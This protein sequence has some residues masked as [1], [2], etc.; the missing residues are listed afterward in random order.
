MPTV[1]IE[2]R[3]RGV[4]G[5]VIAFFFWGWQLVMAGALISG[6][7]GASNHTAALHSEAE[8]AGASIGTGLGVAFVLFLWVLGTIIF[9]FM[10]M[11]TRGRR[12]LITMERS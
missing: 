9:G 11:F 12:E 7:N 2:R 4:F 8:R 10:M 6:L 3:R 1:Q 5:W